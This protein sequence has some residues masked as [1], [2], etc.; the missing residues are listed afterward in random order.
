VV[1]LITQ[2]EF[3]G[4]DLMRQEDQRIDYGPTKVG[5]KTL[6][7]P[8]RTVINA[9]DIPSGDAGAGNFDLRHTMFSVEYKDFHAGS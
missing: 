1:R 7:V 3:K 2:A 5:D 8:V 6:A 9:E 4:S